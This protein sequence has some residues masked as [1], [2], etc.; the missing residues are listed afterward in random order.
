MVI[1]T[2]DSPSPEDLQWLQKQATSGLTPRRLAER[3]QIVLLASEG[4]TNEQI[5][6]LLGISRQ[7]AA[8]W[9]ARFKEAGR[10]G[11]E[12]DASGRG[13]KPVYGPEMASLIVERTLRT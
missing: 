5:A 10:A 9:R 13:R 11:L 7:K 1:A 8:R 3:C 2:S 6:V 4:K 12:H